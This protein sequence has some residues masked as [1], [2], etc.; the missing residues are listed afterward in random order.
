MLSTC[1]ALGLLALASYT[2]GELSSEHVV[3]VP[4]ARRSA[5]KRHAIYERDTQSIN[6]RNDIIDLQVSSTPHHQITFE[7]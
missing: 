3:S 5:P 6:I 2:L 7:G 4:I 1:N